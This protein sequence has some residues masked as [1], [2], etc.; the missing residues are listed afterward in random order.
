MTI[1]LGGLEW[2]PAVFWSATPHEMFA[3]LEGRREANGVEEPLRAPTPE[4]VAAMMAR[5]PDTV[6]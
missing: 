5:F 2:P 4:E 1:A 3:A 6:H